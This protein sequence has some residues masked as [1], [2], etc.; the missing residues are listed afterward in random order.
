MSENTGLVPE[1][2]KEEVKTA[3]QVAKARKKR[4]DTEE[5][6]LRKK[7]K[8]YEKN[9][10]EF[11]R[12]QAEIA[13]SE[14]DFK[15]IHEKNR[16]HAMIVI[17]TT[18]VAMLGYSDMDK[19]CISKKDY[20]NL[21][22]AV[23][24]NIQQMRGEEEYRN[25]HFDYSDLVFSMG[26]MKEEKLCSTSEDYKNLNLKII[27]KVKELMQENADERKNAGGNN[28]GSGNNG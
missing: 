16:T 10:K 14:E 11:E 9:K 5:A 4:R 1:N 3:E 26:F 17:G 18:L 6:N 27:E 2:K 13:K 22:D 15:K 7:R 28:D 25:Y 19:D 8:D 20:N 23:I 24:A 12:L 21:T